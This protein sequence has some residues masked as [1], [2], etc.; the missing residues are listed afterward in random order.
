MEKAENDFR[1]Q[2]DKYT[3]EANEKMRDFEIQS[4]KDKMEEIMVLEK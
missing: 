4:R 1:S 3:K 2:K